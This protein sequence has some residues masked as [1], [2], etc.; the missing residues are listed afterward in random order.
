[1]SSNRLVECA[2]CGRFRVAHGR[3][4]CFRCHADGDRCGPVP[5][6]VEATDAAPGTGDKVAVMQGRALRGEQLFHPGD[7]RDMSAVGCCNC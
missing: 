4:L 1:M 5:L 3:G 2:A 7:S 6:P